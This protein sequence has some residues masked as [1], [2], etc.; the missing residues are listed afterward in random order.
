MSQPNAYEQT[1]KELL[2][3]AEGKFQPNESG[4]ISP[5]DKAKC[6]ALLAVGWEIR[7]RPFTE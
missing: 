4:Y 1:C 6:Y 2:K 7:N 3:N 5:G